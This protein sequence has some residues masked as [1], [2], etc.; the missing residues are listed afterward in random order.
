MDSRERPIRFL[1]GAAALLAGAAAGASGSNDLSALTWTAPGHAR[2]VLSSE[3]AT[4]LQP[5]ADAQTVATGQALFNAPGLLGGQAARAQVSCASCHANGRRNAQFFLAGVSNAPGTADVSASFFS[6][7]RANPTFDPKPIPDLAPPGKVSRASDGALEHF[8]RGLIVEEFAGRE[9]SPAALSALGAYVRA[10]RACPG[11]VDQPRTLDAQLDLVRASIVGAAAM[12]ERGDART[13]AV[14]IGA[15]R[16]QLGLI[17]ERIPGLRAERALLL[18]ASRA[19]QPIGEAASPDAARLR[20][21]TAR[22]DAQVVPSLHRVVAQS[23]YD[24]RKLDR[25]LAKE[26]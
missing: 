6:I 19:L 7:A 20:A 16:H 11:R 21:W 25:W 22:F 12:A 2:E 15:T 4:C 9:P 13:A 23:L 18:S 24:P 17:D 8:M 3:P 5:G 10:I 14:L 26:R 1:I